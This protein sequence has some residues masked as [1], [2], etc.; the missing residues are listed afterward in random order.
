[1]ATVAADLAREVL[2]DDRVREVLPTADAVLEGD[3]RGVSM[4]Q[5]VQLLAAEQQSGVLDVG[6]GGD[7]ALFVLSDG[8][9]DLGALP[10]GQETDLLARVLAHG[11]VCDLSTARKRVAR[12]DPT[13]S[14]VPQAL[15]AGLVGMQD[16]RR[17]VGE[18]TRRALFDVLRWREGRFSFGP[19]DRLPSLAT[20]VGL[21]L[22]LDELLMEGSRDIEDWH[23]IEKRLPDPSAIF[24]REESRLAPKVLERLT[25]EEQRVLDLVDGR[26]PLDAILESAE[27]PSYDVQSLIYRLLTLQLVRVR[28]R[29]VIL[30]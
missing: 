10:P 3:L 29:P 8:R 25:D 7:R 9:L 28:T 11:G 21:S 27:M 30:E 1:V 23:V 22:S 6:S 18:T 12:L 13:L 17:A 15:D 5:V 14:V 4:V 19:A 20:D 26:T 24:V 2:A 16:L